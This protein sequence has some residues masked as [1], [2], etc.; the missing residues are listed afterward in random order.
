MVDD[1][2]ELLERALEDEDF[3]KLICVGWCH[4][5]TVNEDKGLFTFEPE[6]KWDEVKHE[7]R[8]ARDD[9][10]ARRESYTGIENNH[11]GS[12]GRASYAWGE[13]R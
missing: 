2:R 9:R 7:R 1:E 11:E 6:E 5:S 4:Q 13:R 12:A 3:C 10:N 8:A